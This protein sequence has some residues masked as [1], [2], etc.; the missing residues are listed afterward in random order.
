MI[1][2]LSKKT[3]IYFLPFVTT[4]ALLNRYLEFFVD[5]HRRERLQH[6][7]EL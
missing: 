3:N 2:F 4:K 1:Y 7:S 6:R 5:G